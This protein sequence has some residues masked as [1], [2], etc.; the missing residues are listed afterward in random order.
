[1]PVLCGVP[2]APHA[3]N[4]SAV[5]TGGS[6]VGILKEPSVAN[7]LP[8]L[9]PD[10]PVRL[11]FQLWMT[12]TVETTWE[13]LLWKRRLYIQVP[14]DL[15]PEGSKQAFISLLEYAEEILECTH[16]IVCFEKNAPDRAML[17]RI[18]MFLGFATLAPG[19]PLVPPNS[20]GLFMV[21]VIE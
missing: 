18:F 7:K 20:N 17:V 9:S 16:V 13:T 1:M 21:Y 12:D 15:V 3:A 14:K 2:D 10:D 4:V 11:S 8:C 6:G 5:C 19:H